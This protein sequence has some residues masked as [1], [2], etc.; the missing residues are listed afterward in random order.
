MDNGHSNQNRLDK[1]DR[2]V[3]RM[4]YNFILARDSITIQSSSDV[5]RRN[6]AKEKTRDG[7]EI[8]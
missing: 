7:N 1:I 3:D 5:G 8:I 4:Y 2:M 6:S